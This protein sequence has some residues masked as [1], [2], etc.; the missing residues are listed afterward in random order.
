[1][2]KRLQAELWEIQVLLYW[3]L[4]FLI[5]HWGDWH[6]V[7]WISIGYGWFTFVMCYVKIVQANIKDRKHE[8]ERS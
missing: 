1:M 5:I 3:L 7:G 6:W 4:G 8:Q 2:N